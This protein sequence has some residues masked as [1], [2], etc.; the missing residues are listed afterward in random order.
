MVRCSLVLD[1]GPY[2]LTCDC[3]WFVE[4]FGPVARIGPVSVEVQSVH[5]GYRLGLEWPR[6]ATG[7]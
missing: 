3:G 1:N 4:V 5:H 7:P 6:N 2:W